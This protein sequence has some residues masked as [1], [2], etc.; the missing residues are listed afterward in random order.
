MAIMPIKEASAALNVFTL[1]RNTINYIFCYVKNL[2]M[3]NIGSPRVI[4]LNLITNLIT[5]YQIWEI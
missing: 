2:R 5:K 1:W 3:S 4:L